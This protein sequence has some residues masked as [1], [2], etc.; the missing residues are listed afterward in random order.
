MEY[1]EEIKAAIAYIEDRLAQEIRAEDVA[2]AAGFSKYHFHRIFKRET[3]LNLHQYIQRRRLGQAAA[4]L[5][6]SSRQV[7]DI[8]VGL[9]FE[10]QEAFTRAFK[11]SYGLPPGRYRK[12][13][14]NLI[15]GGMNMEKSAEIKQ[16]ITTG[17]A[18]EKYEMGIDHKIFNT[19]TG[20][21]TIRSLEQEYTPEEYATILQQFSAA[22]YTGK[23]VRF[24]AF[25][26]SEA[27]EGWAGL[28]MRLDGNFSVTLKLDN[29]Q[30]RP[31]CGTTQWNLYS[32]V[33]DVPEEAQIINIGILLSGKGQVWMDNVSFQEVDR[34]VPT[35]EF[36]IA[37]E[38]P[39]RPG[40]LSF[41]E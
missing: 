18:P 20:S 2:H 32:C 21:A 31:I 40:N 3:G 38:Y 13:L 35:T 7:L 22:L 37:R 26:K 4:F 34:S 24:A 12:A 1:R 27:V 25:V 29:M 30:N 17:T 5:L 6:N 23:R 10:S 9:G 36:E 14:S 11:K 33:L 8:A 28:W 19:G 41:E 39:D 15:S 16:W